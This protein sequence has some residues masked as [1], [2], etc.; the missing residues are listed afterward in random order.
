[1]G[2]Q[3]RVPNQGPKSGSQIGVPLPISTP[4]PGFRVPNWGP[5]S[6]SQIR[7]QIGVPNWV[8]NQ[9]P[10]LG[11]QIGSQIRQGPK[12]GSQIGV[13]NRGPK[14]GSHIGVPIGGPKSGSQMAVPN[15]GPKWRSQLRVPK[16][17]HFML[18]GKCFPNQNCL[19]IVFKQSHY[20]HLAMQVKNDFTINIQCQ[21]SKKIPKISRGGGVRDLG[22]G[23]VIFS[24][25]GG[26]P[27]PYQHPMAMYACM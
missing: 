13:L 26:V 23:C 25:G 10:K 27:T 9:G 20:L 2:S 12:S 14:S 4:K 17:N 21:T 6:G 22:Q 3:I 18:K 16:A 8:P 24:W 19:R 5:K 7:V 11:S 1:L 15:W